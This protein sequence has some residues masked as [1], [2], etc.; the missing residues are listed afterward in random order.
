MN[1]LHRKVYAYTIEFGKE[2]FFFIPPFSEMSNIIKDVCAAMGELCWAVSSSA[3][4]Q[5]D[6][7]IMRNNFV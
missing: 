5:G 6:E 4:V 1:K 3:E 7:G 2:K